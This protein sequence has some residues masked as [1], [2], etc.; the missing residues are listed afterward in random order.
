MDIKILENLFQ[1]T[2]E[3]RNLWKR[4]DQIIYKRIMVDLGLLK[5]GKVELQ[6]TT[7][8]GNLRKILGIH[9]KKVDPHREELLLGRNAHSA[10]YGETIHDR[11][12]QLVSENFQGQAHFENFIMRSE[13]TEFVNQVKRPSAKS[14]EENGEHCR[15]MYR[16]F[17]NM[18]N[19]YGYNIECGDIYGKEFLNYSKCCQ[20]S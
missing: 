7:D 19:V 12:G 14:T 11:T 13:V 4:H 15:V 18:G 5:S 8:R 17:N 16:T 1:V 10:R 9:C 6:S 20:E 3:R 2:I